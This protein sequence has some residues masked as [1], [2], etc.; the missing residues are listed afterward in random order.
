MTTKV[1]KQRSIRFADDLDSWVEELAK[2]EDR[3]FSSM[4]NSLI[5]QARTRRA[6]QQHPAAAA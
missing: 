6:P 5:R 4:V 2:Q 3:T 1:S